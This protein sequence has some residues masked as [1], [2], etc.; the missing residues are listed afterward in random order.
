MDGTRLMIPMMQQAIIDPDKEHYLVLGAG[1][2]Y[3]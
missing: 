3:S 1:Y 2:E